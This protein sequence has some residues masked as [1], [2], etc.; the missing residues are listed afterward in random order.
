VVYWSPS[1]FWHR[2]AWLRGDR[3][4]DISPDMHWYPGITFWQTTTDLIFANKTPI[5]HGH[6]Y[7]SGTVD[8]W[9]ALAAPPGWT[10]DDTVRLR[11]LLD[12]ER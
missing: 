6:V 9:A 1:L 10:A 4:P 5:G 8:G 3:G 2:P 11:A 7:K 12:R